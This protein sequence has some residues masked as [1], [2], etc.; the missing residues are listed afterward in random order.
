MKWG[1]V[2]Q[3]SEDGR[4][5]VA[6]DMDHVIGRFVFKRFYEVQWESEI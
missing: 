5:R 1:L 3:P 6:R 2:L 4:I